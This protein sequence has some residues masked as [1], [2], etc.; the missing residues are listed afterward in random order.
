MSPRGRLS[1]LLGR[2]LYLVTAHN[3]LFSLAIAL[4]VIVVANLVVVRQLNANLSLGAELG[5]E[6]VVVCFA[7]AI[8]LGL[9]VAALWRELGSILDIVS[10][11]PPR[12]TPTLVRFIGEELKLLRSRID[13]TRSGGIDLDNSAVTPWVR[14]RCFA[15]ASGAY[16]TTDPL[17]PSE[18]LAC[19]P[20]YLRAHAE[21]VKQTS[22]TSSVRINIASREEL[23]RDA[24]ANPDAWSRYVRWHSANSVQLLHL[25]RQQAQEIASENELTETID[26]A[27]WEGELALLVEYRKEGETNLRM[28]VAG[29][30]SY[31]HSMGF[32][33]SAQASA[34]P[35]DELGLDAPSSHGVT[36]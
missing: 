32:I 19:Y 16:R 10:K 18:F 25:D 9:L 36:A 8:P 4:V 11:G 34:I 29:E 6:A 15:V 30:D 21:Y 12:A 3:G 28:A 22:C 5:L 31:A 35:F 20:A 23:S 2:C 17:V 13:E 27:T 33:L 26:V 1:R 7:F 24:L 14:A